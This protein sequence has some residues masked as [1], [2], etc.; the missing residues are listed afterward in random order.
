MILYVERTTEPKHVDIVIP[1]MFRSI[2]A[3]Q[4]KNPDRQQNYLG[5]PRHFKVNHI[6]R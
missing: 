3:Y 6:H 2:T 5:I 1:S 4:C